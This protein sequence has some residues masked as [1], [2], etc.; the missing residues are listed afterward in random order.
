MN[1][2]NIHGLNSIKFVSPASQII[3]IMKFPCDINVLQF[4]G[5]AGQ[6]NNCFLISYLF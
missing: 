5:N 2:K 1:P 4:K 3:M 6:A